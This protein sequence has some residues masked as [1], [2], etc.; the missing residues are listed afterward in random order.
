LSKDERVG[1]R[2][3]TTVDAAVA[4]AL[5]PAAVTASPRTRSLAATASGLAEGVLLV[6]LVALP[7]LVNPLGVAAFEPLKSSFVRVAAALAACAW[8]GYQSR[9]ADRRITVA[10]LAFVAVSGVSTALSI[11]P[12]ESLFGTF[13]RGMGWLTLAAGLVLALVSADLWTDPRRRERAVSALLLGAI[14]PCAYLVVQRLGRDPINWNALGAPGST[15]ASPTF[16]AGYLVVLAPLALYR[17]LATARTASSGGWP[18]TLRYAGWLALLLVIG[19]T[20]AQST[21]RGA[22]L[23]LVAGTLT[24][25]LLMGRP[26]RAVLLASLAFLALAVAL[27]VS[28]TG[29][30]GVQGISRFLSIGGSIDSSTERLVV[31]PDALRQPLGD[32]LRAAIGFGPETQASVLEHAE[33]TVRLSQNEQWDRAHNLLL[34]TWLTGGGAGVIAL[35]ALLGV[36]GWTLFRQRKTLLAAAV[37]GALVGHVVD[38]SFSF[39]TVVTGTLFWVLAGLAASFPSTAPTTSEASVARRPLGPRWALLAGAACLALL[40]VLAAPAI[41]DALYGAGRRALARGDA[42]TAATLDEQ[43]AFWMAWLEEPARAAGLAWLQV[44]S[45]RS[46]RDAAARAES[47]LLD[48]ARRAPGLPTPRVRLLRLYL[49][50]NQLA[51]AEAACQDALVAG[52]YRVS[53]WTA[54]ADVSAQRGLGDEQNQ[55]RARADVLRVPPPR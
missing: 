2:L 7:A 49:S 31:W 42:Q 1:F 48:A 36:V 30:A 18:G 55:R 27:A 17:V 50:R 9:R 44:A 37:L 16:L 10:A 11:D 33:S 46:D 40:P 23:G 34:D 13:S 38:V 52:P 43:A 6:T 29:G 20:I 54:C 26:G 32:G 39:Q 21:I 5:E 8:L 19:G 47:S 15:L 4:T 45:R 3:E 12:A 51:E 28:L 24:F 22:L 14:V 41:G 35:L 25:A 53:V